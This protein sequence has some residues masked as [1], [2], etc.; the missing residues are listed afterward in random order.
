M[1]YEVVTL[2]GDGGVGSEMFG[3]KGKACLKAAAEVAAELERLGVVTNVSGITMKDTTEPVQV[4]M[5]TTVKVER[6]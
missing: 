4:A 6:G 3:F 2:V 5:D 1:A